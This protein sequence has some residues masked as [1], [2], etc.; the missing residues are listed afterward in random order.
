MESN[1]S[2]CLVLS[3]KS[4]LT[5]WDWR[6]LPWIKVALKIMILFWCTSITWAQTNADNK[7][8]RKIGFNTLLCKWH[9]FVNN[10][11]IGQNLKEFDRQIRSDWSNYHSYYKIQAIYSYFGHDPFCVTLL[12]C[13]II[14]RHKTFRIHFRFQW[15]CIL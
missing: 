2:N 14:Q 13:G 1:C 9:W 6:F 7:L 4:F 12:Q 15:K 5:L 8:T 10:T 11:D 3:W